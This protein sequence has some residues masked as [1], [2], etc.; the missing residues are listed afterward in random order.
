VLGRARR[1]AVI[2][3]RDR[4]ISAW[5][6]AGHAVCALL[7]PYADDPVQVTIV[8]R[9]GTGGTTW[10][11]EGDDLLVTRA[12]AQASLIVAMGGRAAEEILLEGDFTSGSSQDYAGARV[13]ATHMVTRLAMG[14]AGVAHAGRPAGEEPTPDVVAAV[15][16][17]LGDSMLAARALVGSSQPLLA[18]IAAELVEEETLDG[19]RLRALRQEFNL[20][21]LHPD[22]RRSV[23][24][25]PAERE[26]RRDQS[27]SVEE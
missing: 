25:V 27:I 7:V 24:P 12:Q 6:E 5:H 8:P 20:V 11:V 10:L 15:S 22:R 23:L 14:P 4:S 2:S 19:K 13:L 17:L 21:E 3:K 26:R 18:A 1:S 9:G 16:Q